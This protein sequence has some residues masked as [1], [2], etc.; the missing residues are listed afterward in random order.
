MFRTSGKNL[1]HQ[2]TCL[3]QLPSKDPELPLGTKLLHTVF[4]FWRIIFGNYYRKLCSKIFLGELITVMYWLVLFFLG[5]NEYLHAQL[6]W[7]HFLSLSLYL[8]ISLSLFLSL[9]LSLFGSL[10][11][12][13]SVSVSVSLSLFFLFFLFSFLSLSLSF[14]ISHHY[15]QWQPKLSMADWGQWVECCRGIVPQ[16]LMCQVALCIFCFL[17]SCYDQL[18]G[19]THPNVTPVVGNTLTIAANFVTSSCWSR[20][21]PSNR[22]MGGGTYVSN[23]VFMRTKQKQEHATFV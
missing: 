15:T 21:R 3:G 2:R 7:E 6:S 10:C 12:S 11:L 23:G 8:F 20:K 1:A 17:S 16:N 22:T 4:S 13:I 14:Y 18:H 5:R 19:I 9:S